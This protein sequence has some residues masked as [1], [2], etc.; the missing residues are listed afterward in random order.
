MSDQYDSMKL[1]DLRQLA[2]ERGLKGVSKKK[3]D[4]LKALLREEDTKPK[5]KSRARKTAKGDAK[6]KANQGVKDEAAVKAKNVAKDTS[7]HEVEDE[8]KDA[9]EAK[10]PKTSRRGRPKGSTRKNTS[11]KQSK[12]TRRT[13][14]KKETT[15]EEKPQ[16][17]EPKTDEGA[18]EEKQQ[19]QQSSETR[20]GVLEVMAD[21]F[22]FLR[23]NLYENSENDVYVPPAQIRRFKLRNGDE[24][25]G[26]IGDKHDKDRYAPLIYVN[27][28][29]GA[30]PDFSRN[31][32][33]FEDLTPIYP[34][35]RIHL[36]TTQYEIS[37]RIIDL[38]SPIGKGQRGLIVSP[39]K[40]GKTTLLKSIA[41]AIEAN[42]P[43]IK[44]IILLI[45]ERPEEVTD[46]ERSVNTVRKKDATGTTEVAAS[47]FD[48]PVQN[49]TKL[50]EVVLERAMH[51]VEAGQDVV[52][53]LDS[54][55]RLSRA[56]NIVS[57]PSGRTLSGGL[58]PVAL[59]KP[60]KF[61]GAAR[62]IDGAG[63]LT[64]LATCLLDTGSRMDDM[65]YEEFKGTG[66]MEI[67]LSRDLA[68]VRVF[69]AIDIFASGTRKDEKL[70]TEAEQETMLK[71][72]RISRGKN[73]IQ[74]VES[75]V[76]LVK[77]TP[78]NEALCEILLRQ[79]V[80]D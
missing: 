55:T 54:L 4:E 13:K 52:I 9:D 23:M 46:M 70:L 74:S 8:A 61:F 7:K 41:H 71:I 11:A 3:K 5:V 50:S 76:K 39:P 35:E 25:S 22:G 27:T 44:L 20:S 19:K 65:I 42:H 66:N 17:V 75:F 21:G 43:D 32:T 59:Y 6:A 15:A 14:S 37:N 10:T 16:A 30:R 33:E 77:N 49:H 73:P 80:N 72:R 12:N 56:Y 68:E 1:N 51:L 45:D 29:N 53:L 31:R 78:N 69:P 36:E 48:K 67:H 40:A 24:I 63:S 64:I 47:T 60:K 18:E 2:Q 62:N 79:N 58:D 28:V 34:D 57:P 26:I 38:V